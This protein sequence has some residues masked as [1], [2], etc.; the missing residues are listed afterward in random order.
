MVMDQ[1]ALR[2]FVEWNRAIF[3][4]PQTYTCVNILSSLTASS[5]FWAAWPPE[6][7]DK[8]FH[9]AKLVL[10][11]IK[12]AITSKLSLFLLVSSDERIPYRPQRWFYFTDPRYV[13]IWHCSIII[14]KTHFKLSIS[15]RISVGSSWLWPL[16]EARGFAKQLVE[17]RFTAVCTTWTIIVRT[18]LGILIKQCQIWGTCLLIANQ[19]N[20]KGI[21]AAFSSYKQLPFKCAVVWQVTEK[22]LRLPKGCS[23]ARTSDYQSEL[24]FTQV[25]FESTQGSIFPSIWCQL[26]FPE[27]YSRK[28]WSGFDRMLSIHTWYHYKWYF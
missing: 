7:H 23:P 10:G 2:K 17:K 28:Q 16:T 8:N 18:D 4:K 24:S 1:D 12:T 22:K 25:H 19:N 21:I 27:W 3:W 5:H 20:S 6:R 15:L 13:S 9:W 11:V 26:L 14:R